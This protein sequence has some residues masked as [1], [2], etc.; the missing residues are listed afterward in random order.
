MPNPLLS[1]RDVEFLLYHVHDAEGLCSLPPFREFSRG[2]F[3]LFLQTV[4][5]FAREDLYPSYRPMDSDPPV[6]DAGRVRVHPRMQSLYP[7][8]VEL[9]LLTATRPPEVGGQHI[10]LTV[11]S[12]AATYL[13]AANASAFGFAFLTTGA[14]HLIEA[15]GSPELKER[16]MR[17][18][19]EGRFTGTMALTEPQAGSS[20]ADVATRAVPASDGSYRVTG[21][22]IF[23]SGGDNDFVDNVV[24]LTLARIEGAPAG[25]RGLSL[26]AIPRLRP[27]GDGWE[28]N[29][30]H[31]AG[32]V[33]KI[34]WK[35]LPSLIL[36]F[37][38]R[39]DCRGW[40]VGEA[41][42][43]LSHMFQM[44]N[45]A[46]ILVGLNA[47]STA[48]VAYQ[49][50]LEYAQIRTQGRSV[51]E[52]DPA[53]KPVPIVAHA[54]VRR[55]LLRQK[56]I[57]EG[58]LSLLLETSRAADLAEHAADA[59]ERAGARLL[60]DLLTPVAKTFAAERG[61]ESNALALQIHG[62]YGYSSEYPVEAWLRD[63]KL[64]SIHEGTSGIQAMDL[65]GR[66][67]VAQGGAVFAGFQ[68]RVTGDIRSAREAGVPAGWCDS[69][70]RA[71][72]MIGSLTAELGMIGLSGDA[73]RMLRN[74]SDYMD[75]FSAMC[76][77]WQ[78][79][80]QATSATRLL[81]KGEGDRAFLEGKR[82]AAQYWFA[83]EVSRVPGLVDCCRAADDSH[84]RMQVD[85]F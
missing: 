5:R 80:K 84:V 10:P 36:S 62:G 48:A 54:D 57:T 52:R 23:I 18:M 31:V 50:A 65:L 42:R 46:R 53:S 14:A 12:A 2:D 71:L 17:P 51:T 49:E 21:S 19:Y 69:L 67:V 56:A 13:M 22:K 73:E 26:L 74:A 33:H 40:L 25:T 63:Q 66:K 39:N 32:M 59:G 70:E 37:G 6:L 15:F 41:N 60:V 72:A 81:D 78:W 29:D 27:A 35:A 61:F 43:G 1:D 64:N 83:N 44:M 45:E 75:A 38:E 77:G 7:R 11:F 20:L 3:D 47:A 55:M 28:D 79:L 16:F 34:G 9:G 82:A 30:V 4:R 58:A 24:H 76:V 68:A 85:W 8:I